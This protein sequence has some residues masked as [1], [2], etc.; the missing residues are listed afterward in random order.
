MVYPDPPFKWI[1][2]DRWPDTAAKNRAFSIF[3][4]LDA[5]DPVTMGASYDDDRALHYLG[6]EPK[7]QALFDDSRT[8]WKIGCARVAI[9][10]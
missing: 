8:I 9:R 1:N 5:I 2:V 3:K 7:A 6:F 10:R 4:A